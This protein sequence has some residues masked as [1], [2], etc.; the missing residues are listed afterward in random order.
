MHPVLFN[1]GSFSVYSYGFCIALAFIVSVY[2]LRI[3]SRR[4][5]FS[6]DDIMDCLF[7]VLLGGFIGGRSLHV[8]VNSQYY[9]DNPI[10]IIALRD[11]GMSIFGSII[12][13]FFLGVVKARAK[14][15]PVLKV[16]DIIV[17]YAALG[18][19]IGRVGCFLNG[20]CYGK[21]TDSPIG[22][23]FNLDVVQR[24]PVQ[25]YFSAMLLAVFFVL[26]FFRRRGPFPGATFF[27]Y[28]I[29]Y[30]AARFFLEFLRDDN[31]VVLAGMK[32]TQI[33]SVCIFLI[34]IICFAIGMNKA[35][36]R[37]SE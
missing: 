28:L 12:M 1:I 11:G 22:V 20:C 16:A 36:K 7:W 23:T 35:V 32:L 8:L 33:L 19:S 27:M 15:L 3:D 26:L 21:I 29:I 5:D 17:P 34:G 13:G 31:P 25:L 2:L 18:Q 14:G 30:P 4:L 37:Q 24:I 9:F 10:K 6:F